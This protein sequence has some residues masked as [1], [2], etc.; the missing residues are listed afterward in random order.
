MAQF[1]ASSN[2]TVAASATQLAVHVLTN[3]TAGNLAEVKMITWGGADTSLISAQV[4]WSRVTNT[5]ATPT[6]LTI[7]SS[8]PA[9]TPVSSVNTY[10]TAA[11]ATAG[12]QLFLDAWNQQGGGGIVNLPIGGGW[13]ISG[14]ALGTTYSQIGCGTPAGSGTNCTFG[15]QFEE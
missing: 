4:R 1:S 12:V 11:T 14:G 9:I 15:L 2:P 10:G 13:K 6:A 3:L 8:A 5:A 7:T